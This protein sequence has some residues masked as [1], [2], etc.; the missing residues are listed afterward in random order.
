M[1]THDFDMTQAR[2]FRFAFTKIKTAHVSR[3]RQITIRLN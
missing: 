1:D 2:R 3:Q